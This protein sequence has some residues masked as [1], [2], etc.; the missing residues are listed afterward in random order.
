[1]KDDEV[2]DLKIKTEKHDHEINLKPLENDNKN[3]K[4]NYKNLIK[5]SIFPYN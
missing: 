4:K 3:Y 1:M 5:K 2:K